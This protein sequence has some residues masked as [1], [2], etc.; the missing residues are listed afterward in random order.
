MNLPSIIKKD[1]NKL[2]E[3]FCY[4]FIFIVFMG[5]NF[6]KISFGKININIER[7]LMIFIALFVFVDFL[8]NKGFKNF[9][10]TKRRDIKLCIVF[11]IIWSIYSVISFLWIKDVYMYIITNFNVVIGTCVIIY[12]LNNLQNIRI[13]ENILKIS[14]LCVTINCIYYMNVRNIYIGGFYHNTNDL[15]TVLLLILPSIIYYMYHDLNNTKKLIFRFIEYII[16]ITAFLFINSRGCILGIVFGVCGIIL[17]LFLKNKKELLNNKKIVLI[18]LILI[19][20]FVIFFIY[21]ISNFLSSI[22]LKPVK[23]ATNSNQ[24][25]INL[26]Y[27]AIEFLKQD[28]NLLKGIGA[29]SLPYYYQNYSI[30]SLRE[31]YSPHNLWIQILLE[32]GIVIFILFVL[33]WLVLLINLLKNKQKTKLNYVFLFFTC[34]MTIAC[35]S[36]STL[37]T[38]E[39]FWIIMGIVLAWCN[40]FGGKENE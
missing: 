6:G 7:I 33:V 3:Y 17:S 40:Q 37:L 9:I 24:I 27:N 20:V 26:F 8:K 15:A 1:K 25:R 14:I 36:S 38:R 16:C 21:F 22:S 12:F 28:M 29:G 23:V 32:Y 10:K 5:T 2:V 34:A 13:F 18:S 30:Y 39:Y 35:I 11:F 4:I 31:I 19:S